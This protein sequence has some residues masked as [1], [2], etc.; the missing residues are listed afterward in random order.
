MGGLEH[1]VRE[2][3]YAA[4]AGGILLENFG[5]PTPGEVLLIT[6]A[7]AA[8]SGTLD[9][10]PL[11]LFAWGA[12]VAG[13]AIG[14]ALGRY[15]GHRL[16]VRYG[17]RIGVTPLRLKRVE[18]AFDRFGDWVVVFARFIVV[19]RQLT[20]IV[21]GTLEMRWLRFLLLTAAGAALWV[22]WWGLATYFFGAGVMEFLHRAGRIEPV[23]IAAAAIVLVA[24]VL[25]FRWNRRRGQ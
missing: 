7:I 3:G 22:L 12:A 20:G 19:L 13:N 14:W 17:A 21:A 24:L 23:L 2:Y 6:G 10:V 8:A 16:L 15:G 18:A 1:F 11:L 4:V 25:R 5:L 9:I